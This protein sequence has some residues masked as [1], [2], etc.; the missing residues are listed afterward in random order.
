MWPVRPREEGVAPSGPEGRTPASS[1]WW[2]WAHDPRSSSTSTTSPPAIPVTRPS[3][4]A[5]RRSG[6][7]LS[8][9]GRPRD[10][11]PYLE[12]RRSAAR[13]HEGLVVALPGVDGLPLETGHDLQAC[14]LHG[15]D[16]LI[17]RAQVP[18]QRHLVPE[19][20]VGG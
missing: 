6:E 14:C 18:D 11:C 20:A 3:T 15:V 7:D 12:R 16:D 1:S 13:G 9:V 10:R 17:Q 4:A 19:L 5:T 8:D 2:A